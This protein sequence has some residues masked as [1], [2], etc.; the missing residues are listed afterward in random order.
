MVGGILQTRNL[1]S[2]KRQAFD[3]DSQSSDYFSS[4]ILKVIPTYVHSLSLPKRRVV[5]RA[6]V[7]HRRGEAG[8][9]AIEFAVVV[10]VMLTI[11]AA[12]IQLSVWF[13]SYQTAAHAAREGARRY[14]V[15]PCETATNNTLVQNRVGSA[16]SGAVTVSRTPTSGY[17]VGSNVTVTVT[18]ATHNLTAGLIP[19]PTNITKSAT[20]R[21]E[22]VTGCP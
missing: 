12:I 16:A 9:A 7:S 17:T 3:K 10:L 8:A 19:M 20:A 5:L 15:A 2:A 18:F 14:A 21:V 4:T 22:D 6:P 13:W 1:G 11:V